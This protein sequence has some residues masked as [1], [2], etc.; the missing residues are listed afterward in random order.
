MRIFAFTIAILFSLFAVVQI[1]DPDPLLWICLYL[2]VTIYSILFYLGKYYF[3]LAGI[4][5]IL[6]F[7]AAFFLF[8][9]S[10]EEWVEAENTSRSFTMEMPMVEDAREALG[11]LISSLA[12]GIYFLYGRLKKK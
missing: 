10:L 4:L 6:Y 5:A 9:F 3:K 8:P 2:I 12:F 1:N 7:I 11:L